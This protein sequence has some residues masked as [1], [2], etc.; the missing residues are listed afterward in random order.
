MRAECSDI[1]TSALVAMPVDEEMDIVNRAY[2]KTYD[3]NSLNELDCSYIIRGS[4]SYQKTYT[5]R[6]DQLIRFH[7]QLTSEE[8]LFCAIFLKKEKGHGIKY[9]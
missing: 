3:F 2:M 9:W 5:V 6:L 8:I 4:A 1:E 7:V